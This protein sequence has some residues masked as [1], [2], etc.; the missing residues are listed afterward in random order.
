MC[1][2]TT[3]T[4]EIRLQTDADAVDEPNGT[5]TVTLGTSSDESYALTTDI[6]ASVEVRDNDDDTL[7]EISITQSGSTPVIEGDPLEFELT[8]ANPPLTDGTVI[9]VNVRV[10]ETGNFLATPAKDTAQRYTVAVGSAGGI[11]YRYQRHADAV[12]EAKCES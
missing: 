4:G 6:T 11:R 5:I 1:L 12:D 10:T 2:A 7:P 8:A 3:K 9:L